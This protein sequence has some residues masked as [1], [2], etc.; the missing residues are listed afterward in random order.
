LSTKSPIFLEISEA[1]SPL[2]PDLALPDS[3][4]TLEKD[5]QI[6]DREENPGGLKALKLVTS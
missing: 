3:H 2:E 6:V 4:P 1:Y 5:I